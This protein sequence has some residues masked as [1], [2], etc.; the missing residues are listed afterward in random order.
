MAFD[1][2]SLARLRGK[3]EVLDHLKD[4][5]REWKTTTE[6]YPTT[7]ARR[8]DWSSITSWRVVEGEA[9]IGGDQVRSELL[10][11]ESATHTYTFL[12]R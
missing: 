2:E 8:V 3:P 5:S 11:L 7:Y 12:P 6:R 4:T 9:R 10:I 1:E